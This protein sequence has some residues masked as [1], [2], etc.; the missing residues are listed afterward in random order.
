[1]SGATTRGFGVAEF[2][3]VGDLIAEVLDALRG[4]AGDNT[5]AERSV[6]AR[7]R[8][9]TARFPIYE[10]ASDSTPA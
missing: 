10:S 3:T 1:V 2:E 4:N 7:T 5:A 6:L 8:E 9:I